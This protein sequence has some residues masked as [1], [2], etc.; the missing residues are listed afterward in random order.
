MRAEKQKVADWGCGW[1]CYVDY[2]SA[3]RTKP[4]SGSNRLK[5]GRL[6]GNLTLPPLEGDGSVRS[7]ENEAIVRRECED[8]ER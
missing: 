8:R 3:G 7:G 1:T 6:R 4:T 2:S 5:N